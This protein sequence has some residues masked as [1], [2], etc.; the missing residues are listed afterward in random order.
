MVGWF[1]QY[2]EVGL[3][4]HQPAENDSRRF[5]AGESLR[6]FERILAAEEH[7]TEQS[8]QF[9]LRC[10]WIEA[11]EP[12]DNAEAGWDGVPMIL[13]EVSDADLMAPGHLPGIDWKHL[14][15]SIDE[16][17]RISNQG[18]QKRGFAG[19]IS[20]DQRDLLSA[21]HRRCEVVQHAEPAGCSVV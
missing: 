21:A 12:F 13:L 19:A 8:P 9:L 2:Q 3:L 1:V 4:E 10:T 15:R 16:T 20:S 11:V 7:L 6:L 18:F 14:I 5:A 17:R